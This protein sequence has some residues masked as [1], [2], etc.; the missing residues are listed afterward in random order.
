METTVRVASKRPAA[1]K[2][3]IPAIVITLT[4]IAATGRGKPGSPAP[5]FLPI[6]RKACERELTE[7]ATAARG[8]ITALERL[9]EPTVLALTAVDFLGDVRVGLPETLRTIVQQAERAD[10][11]AVPASRGFGSAARLTRRRR[12]P[13]CGR[14]LP[15]PD[16][17]ATDLYH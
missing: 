4:T 16:R 13:D 2:D 10:V 14:C 8:L 7:L 1:S 9:H 12:R 17:Q 15:H 3:R 6:G 11:S 5:A